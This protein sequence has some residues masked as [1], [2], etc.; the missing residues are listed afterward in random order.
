MDV[1]KQQS[2]SITIENNLIV[3]YSAAPLKLASP[4]LRIQFRIVVSIVFRRINV[5]GIIV[6]VYRFV[7]IFLYI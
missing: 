7:Y 3:I 1:K 5:I 6:V 4:V 2:P